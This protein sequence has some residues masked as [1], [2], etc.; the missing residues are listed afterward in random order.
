MPEKAKRL[1][2]TLAA[3]LGVTKPVKAERTQMNGSAALQGRSQHKSKQP[4]QPKRKLNA[5]LQESESGEEQGRIQALPMKQR[6]AQRSQQRS[7]DS[8]GNEVRF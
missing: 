3:N 1:A 7:L 5:F 8:S 6:R 4:K 2:A